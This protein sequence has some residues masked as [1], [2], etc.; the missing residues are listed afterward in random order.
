MVGVGPAC[1]TCDANGTRRLP[2]R[3]NGAVAVDEKF[4]ITTHFEVLLIVPQA[5]CVT[6]RLRS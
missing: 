1:G 5:I 2:G 4:L 3:I 6:N